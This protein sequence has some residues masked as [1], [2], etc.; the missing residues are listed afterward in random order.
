[1]GRD[2]ATLPIGGVT[3]AARV[4]AVLASVASPCVEV[5]P[6]ASGLAS[7]RED[8]LGGGPLVAL[9]AG[10]GAVGAGTP[11]LV[12]AC[13]LPRLSISLLTWLRDHPVSGTVVPVW[14][15][16][17]QPLCA[18]WAPDALASVAGLV[19]AGDRS[20]QAL[21][22]AASAVFVSP[23]PSLAHEL[24]DVDTPADLKLV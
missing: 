11:A 3:L 5:G 14:D 10:V 22:S 2:K 17:P 1:M 20:M 21:L 24:L 4:G 19:A 15:S 8:P 13:D 12:V 18:R 16:R 6:G 7:V 9:L 23:P